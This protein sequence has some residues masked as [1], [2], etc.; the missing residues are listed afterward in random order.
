M[1]LKPE[2]YKKALLAVI[3]KHYS[4]LY[5]GRNRS[6]SL[7]IAGE[8]RWDQTPLTMRHSEPRLV[9]RPAQDVEPTEPYGPQLIGY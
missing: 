2:R 9:I 6:A 4:Y 8:A 3:T 1:T 5:G 7:Q